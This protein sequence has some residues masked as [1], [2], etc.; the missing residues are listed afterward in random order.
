[1]IDVLSESV[2]TLPVVPHPPLN[3]W[4]RFAK[5]VHIELRWHHPEDDESLGLTDY[6][7]GT[8][9][10]RTDLD[11]AQRRSTILHE[12]LHV[13]R[14][15][16]ADVPVLVAREELRVGREAA[17]LLLPDICKVGDALA[18]AQNYT[19]AADELWVDLDTLLDRLDS[20][21]PVELHYLRR[22]LA[23]Q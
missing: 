13:E 8:I 1:M 19:E 22:R 12:L 16:A 6:D 21:H 5:L 15:P 7:A 23:D 11:Q 10:L 18:W 4:R 2:P 17:R 9:S 14:G 3:P 20:L